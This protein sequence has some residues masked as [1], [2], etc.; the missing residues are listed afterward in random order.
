MSRMPSVRPLSVSMRMSAFEL[1]MPRVLFSCVQRC[2][3]RWTQENN[4]IGHAACCSIL[5]GLPR[6][7]HPCSE[8]TGAAGQSMSLRS[9]IRRSVAVLTFQHI[10]AGSPGTAACMDGQR[11]AAELLRPYPSAEPSAEPSA[12]NLC[13]RSMSVCCNLCCCFLFLFLKKC[14]T[15]IPINNTV[16]FSIVELNLNLVPRAGYK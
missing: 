4:I 16:H 2:V 6:Q 11:G 5:A 3:Q 7:Q 8:R 9:C 14:Y 15:L 10:S 12:N 1:L 13:C